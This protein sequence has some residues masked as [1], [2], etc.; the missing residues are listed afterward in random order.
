MFSKPGWSV[1]F[2]PTK[3]ELA[4]SGDLAYEVGT[5]RITFNDPEG[6]P[7]TIPAKYVVAWRKDSNHEWKAVADIFNTDK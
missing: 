6:H 3:I 1:S 5:A 2:G 7:I 4:K